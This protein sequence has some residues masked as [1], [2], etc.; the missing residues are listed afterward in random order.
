MDERTRRI[1]DTALQLAEVDGFD[2]VRLRDVAARAHVALGTVY[3]RFRTKEDILVAAL[4]REMGRLQDL[5]DVFATRGPGPADRLADAF[6]WLTRALLA[7]P[8]LARALLRAVASGV[9]EDTGRVAQFHGR[10]T[11]AIAALLSDLRGT[12]EHR[13]RIARLMQDIWFARLVGWSGGLSDV[14]GVVVAMRDA[15]HW[16]VRPEED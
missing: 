6:G 11:D 5:V 4:E 14:D 15:A 12:D 10:T 9:P 16:L 2:S 3:R 1:V 7:R 13:A 8:A